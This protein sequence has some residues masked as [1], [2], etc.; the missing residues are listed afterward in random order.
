MRILIADDSEVFVQRLLRALG[1]IGGVE[2][3]AQAR[4]GA[5]AMQAVRNLNPEVMILDIRMPQGSGIDVLEGM[6]RER[7]APITIVLTNFAYPQYRKKCLQLGA[8]F[9]FD[10]SAEFGKVGEALRRLIHRA[11]ASSEEASDRTE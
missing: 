7:Q 3:V 5:E 8:R 6:K 4:T 9:F 2:I 11:S 10:K 1:E